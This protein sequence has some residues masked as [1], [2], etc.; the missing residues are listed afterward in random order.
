LLH[1][2]CEGLESEGD[3][4]LSLIPVE[5]SHNDSFLAVNFSPSQQLLYGLLVFLILDECLFVNTGV[6]DLWFVPRALHFPD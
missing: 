6:N 4:L 5:T 3:I 2:E 1:V